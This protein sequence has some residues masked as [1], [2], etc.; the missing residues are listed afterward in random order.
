MYLCGRMANDWFQFRRFLV[1]QDRCAMKVGTDGVLLGAWAPLDGGTP[2]LDIGTGTGIVSLVA[3]QRL[4]RDM[5]RME[6]CITAIELDSAASAQ[7]SDNFAAS[8]WKKHMECLNV[9]VNKFEC[10][11]HFGTILCNPP[12]F[13][14]SL[15]CPDSARNS[16]RHGDD[17]S[18]EDLAACVARLLE[19]D[20]LFS[21]ILPFDS[22]PTFIRAFA[23][24]ALYPVR[25]TDVCTVA[26]K[27]PKRTLLAFSHVPSL[28]A[29][30]LLALADTAGKTSA[31][32]AALVKNIYVNI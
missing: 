29:G 3:A 31:E 16:A 26:G 19:P 22:V 24:N 12:Y 11:F 4:E 10:G 20:G 27:P 32:Y 25:R 1:R 23:L 5:C 6:K 18:F 7:A 28:C 14:N 8:P 21:A 9:D 15:R 30:N 2:V 17:L 13:R